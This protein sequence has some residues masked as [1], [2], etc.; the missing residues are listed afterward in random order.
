VRGQTVKED[1]LVGP[2]VGWVL[3][4][5]GLWQTTNDGATWI[6]AY[7]RRLIASAIR[8][9]G[10]LDANHAL[11]AA[12][13]EGPTTST[14]YIW[15]TSDAGLTWAYAALPPIRHDPHTGCAPGDFCGRPGD[16]AASFDYVDANTAF[17]TIGMGEGFDG[18]HSYIF[19]TTDGGLH[20]TPRAWA[21]SLLPLGPDPIERVQFHTPTMGVVQGGHEIASTTTGW[22]HWNDRLFSTDAFP[23]PTVYFLSPDYWVADLGLDYGTVHYWYATTTNHGVT[24]VNHTSNVPGLAGLSEAQV[25]FLSPTVWIGTCSTLPGFVTGPSTTIYTVDGGAHWAMYG[26]QPFNG[27]V[28]TFIDSNHG[29]AGPSDPLRSGAPYTTKLWTTTDRGLH[30]TLITP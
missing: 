24:W 22:G 4:T 1:V 27:S 30:W 2:G 28:A 6:N 23:N 10:A 3:T 17:V 14:Y 12:V 19:G 13:D 7:P 15:H 18:M 5:T 8:G 26:H 29:W 9:L 16:P 20:W 11:L 21:P 25:H